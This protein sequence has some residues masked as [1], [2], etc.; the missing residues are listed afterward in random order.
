MSTSHS[1]N[2]EQIQ[3]G[4]NEPTPTWRQPAR[5]LRNAIVGHGW[6]TFVTAAAIAV[7]G[8]TLQVTTTSTGVHARP[9]APADDNLELDQ[10]DEVTAQEVHYVACML[11]AAGTPD[12]LEHWVDPCRARAA[13]A[14]VADAYYVACMLDAAGTPDS[15]EHWVDPCRARAADAVV[16]D[17]HFVACMLNAPATPDAL[18][19]WVDTCNDRSRAGDS[20]PSQ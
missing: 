10:P 3:S 12:S 14:V 5:L 2:T 19:H 16:A 1:P 9:A 15:L 4:N 8:L 11:D 7:A 13:D 17:A 18:E 20:T 6:T